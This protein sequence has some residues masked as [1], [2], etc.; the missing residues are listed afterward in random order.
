VYR[1][2]DDGRTLMFESI[3]E[4]ETL[5]EA[6]AS[7]KPSQRE[8]LHE[9][10]DRLLAPVYL[11]DAEGTVTYFNPACIGFTGRTPAKGKD[12]WCVTWKLHTSDGSFLPHDCC[13]MAEAIR[14]K[15]PIRGVAA[16]AERPDGTRVLFMPYPTPI[17]SM[18]GTLLGA[19]NIL[20]DITDQRQAEELRS[21]GARCRRLAMNNF[22]KELHSLLLKMAQEYEQ[23]AALLCNARARS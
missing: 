9:I 12:K 13:P 5:S 14:S 18:D 10:L 1:C 20:L 17:I 23:A 11:T 16:V 4:P 2:Q 21:Q 6:I 15:R 3:T 19:V 7:A 8:S 22:D